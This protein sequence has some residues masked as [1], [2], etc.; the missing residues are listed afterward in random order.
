MHSLLW[1]FKYMVNALTMFPEVPLART[2]AVLDDMERRYREGGHSPQAVYKHRYLVARHLGDRD[3]M[4]EW[5]ERWLTTPRDNLSD[6][7]GCDPSAQVAFLAS[8][9][10]DDDAIA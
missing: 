8:E 7:V 5:Y 2:Y 6:C 1:Y 9:G 4:R 3:A 10:R